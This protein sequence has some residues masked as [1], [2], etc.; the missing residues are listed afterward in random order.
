MK[1]M[2]LAGF[3]ANT[4]KNFQFHNGHKLLRPDE[5]LSVSE[6]FVYHSKMLT[7]RLSYGVVLFPYFIYYSP[8]LHML[9]LQKPGCK[10]WMPSACLCIQ[11]FTESSSVT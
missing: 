11:V 1:K 9:I 6:D 2:S 3:C 5:R 7:G 8:N 4:V 10:Y